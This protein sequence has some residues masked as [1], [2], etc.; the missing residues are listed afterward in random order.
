MTLP[1]TAGAVV[2]AALVSGVAGAMA[3]Q[4][5]LV[6]WGIV[7]GTAG[8][9]VDSI[10][11]ATLQGRFHCPTCGADS[12]HR[13]HRCGSRTTCTGGLPWLTNDGV[14]AIATAAGAAAGWLAWRYLFAG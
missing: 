9:I 10:L 3:A 13:V 12:E 14:N 6:Y 5:R 7:I 1:G 2:G 4:P 8:M 11:G